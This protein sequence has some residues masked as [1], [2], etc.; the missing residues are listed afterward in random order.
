MAQR[1]GSAGGKPTVEFI[2]LSQRVE[3]GGHIHAIYKQIV[4]LS[5]NVAN[6]GTIADDRLH[7]WQ[8]RSLGFVTLIGFR[9]EWQQSSL[10]R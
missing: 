1:F 3:A 10:Q 6:I 4:P 8:N 7:Q 2:R 9:V 5:D